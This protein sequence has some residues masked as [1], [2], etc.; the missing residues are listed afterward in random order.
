MK[1]FRHAPKTLSISLFLLLL[2]W[3]FNLSIAYLVFLALRFP[4][5]WSTI[6]ITSSI[7]LAV[8]SIPLG[9]PFE[10]GL[11]EI[12][13]TTLYTLLG[14]PVGISATATILNRIIT[15]WFRFFIG[16]AAQQWLEIKR[17]TA[18]GNTKDMEKI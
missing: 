7:V 8:K 14:V 9:V 13:M 15:L 2:T 17:I 11:P 4:I 16:F 5:Q 6:L 18:S 1:E 12:T 3:I 10:V